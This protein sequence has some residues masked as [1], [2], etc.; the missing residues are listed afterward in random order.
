MAFVNSPVDGTGLYKVTLMPLQSCT[1]TVGHQIFFYNKDGALISVHNLITGSHVRVEH[2]MGATPVTRLP[3]SLRQAN[4]LQVDT[5]YL[6][7]SRG[8]EGMLLGPDL[9]HMYFFPYSQ[10]TALTPVPDQ[11][12]RQPVQPRKNKKRPTS[13]NEAVPIL[14]HALETG[15]MD[16]FFKFLEQIE[17]PLIRNHTILAIHHNPK[18]W[19]L[20]RYMDALHRYPRGNWVEKMRA[21]F[22]TVGWLGG[23]RART[24]ELAVRAAV[25]TIPPT[26]QLVD[27]ILGEE[28]HE[29]EEV[30]TAD[31]QIAWMVNSILLDAGEEPISTAPVLCTAQQ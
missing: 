10:S 14:V 24:E 9:Q 23:R 6:A 26:E 20:L 3:A 27:E 8:S 22:A 19:G 25:A 16:T 13:Q 31:V 30:T 15:D 2:Y 21:H 18:N 29:E 7:M 12:R 1:I 4:W 11:L 28:E 5:M 17:L